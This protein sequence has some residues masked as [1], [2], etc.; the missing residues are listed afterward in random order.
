MAEFSDSSFTPPPDEDT[1]Y[2]YF[3]ARY[4]TAYLQRYIDSHVYNGSSLRSRVRYGCHV[5]EVKKSGNA[6]KILCHKGAINIV[7]ARLIVA[8]GLTSTPSVPPLPNQ[9]AFHARLSIRKT[10]LD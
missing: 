8:T 3:P 4:V 6:W 5:E 7:S 2:G 1:Y 10:S 9:D